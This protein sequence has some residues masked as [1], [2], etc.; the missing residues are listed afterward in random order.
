MGTQTRE[1]EIIGSTTPSTPVSGQAEVTKKAKTDSS[2]AKW[3]MKAAV[4]EHFTFTKLNDVKGEY[5]ANCKHCNNTHYKVNSSRVCFTCDCWSVCT[6]RGFLTLTAYI[7]DSNWSIGSHI[8]NF[9][10]FPLPHRGV[11]IY[12]FVV[13]LRKEWSLERK[14]FSITY[15]NVEAMDVMVARLKSDLLSFTSLLVAGCFFQVHY[16]AHILNLIVQSGMNVIDKSILKLRK[17][18]NYNAGSDARCVHFRKMLDFPTRW[19]STYLILK[20]ALEAKDAL[21]L[22]AIVDSSFDFSLTSM[23]ISRSCPLHH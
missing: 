21:V 20:R 7:I 12:L 3:K 19:N 16:S 22:F 1:L 10:Y 4:W 5:E 17:A 18:V 9:C 23:P 14:A 8:L 2:Y 15:D 6:T 13:G 11:D